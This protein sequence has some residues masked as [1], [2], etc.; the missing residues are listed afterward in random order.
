MLVNWSIH[1]SLKS[2]ATLSRMKVGTPY[3]MTFCKV[4][5]P[6]PS[7][8]KRAME[9]KEHSITENFELRRQGVSFSA[10]NHDNHS[11]AR[12]ELSKQNLGSLPK[13]QLALLYPYLDV[14]YTVSTF[15]W[16]I[17]KKNSR[18]DHQWESFWYL[19]NCNNW[20]LATCDCWGTRESVRGKV[21]NVL[22]QRS[23]MILV[24]LWGDVEGFYG[25]FVCLFV[26]CSFL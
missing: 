13:R 25:E 7:L 14:F 21:R 8:P 6:C 3:S 19:I 15:Y 2:T 10:C 24:M 9:G 5:N 12:G 26:F 20:K 16:G 23:A 1:E 22:L 17:A 4:L 11:I 18:E